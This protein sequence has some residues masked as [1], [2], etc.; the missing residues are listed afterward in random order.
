MKKI[1]NFLIVT[2][3]AI[4]F[5]DIVNAKASYSVGAYMTSVD[6]RD[7]ATVAYNSSK[8]MGYSSL[9]DTAPTYSSLTN[10]INHMNNNGG[11]ILF[12]LGHGNPDMI[13]WNHGAIARTSAFASNNYAHA[14]QDFQLSKI[15]MAL[16][17]GCGT[18]S[19]ANTN[20]PKTAYNGGKGA[21]RTCGWDKS[22]YDED[23]IT[24]VKRFYSKI[25]TGASFLQSLK[26]ANNYNYKHNTNMKSIHY[27]GKYGSGIKNAKQV[28]STSL[29]SSFVGDVVEESSKKY[30]IGRNINI[31]KE[32]L[33]LY[34]KNTYDS[35]F[36]I[37]DYDYEMT[38]DENQN[39]KIHDFNL[40]INNAK[41]NIGYTIFEENGKIELYDHMG[42][43][44]NKYLK[45]NI[46]SIVKKNKINEK[47]LIEE[48]L[49]STTIEDNES[50]SLESVERSYD[51]LT[52]KQYLVI[53]IMVHNNKFDTNSIVSKSF[54]I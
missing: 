43:F 6:S 51:V 38:Y 27:Y 25:S 20:L 16:F 36:D 35:N 48:A 49:S 11:G 40:L 5:A 52:D 13:T 18:T 24:W 45:K 12:F 41:T 53:N 1:I 34:I 28:L 2:M 29:L 10:G 39:I 47:A 14:I 23:T 32:N 4:S 54:E 15:D 37:K 31:T 22:I 9:L 42:N 46:T 17:M 7:E 33:E 19:N 30:S 50:K 8:K 3:L 21:K 26:Y 44:K